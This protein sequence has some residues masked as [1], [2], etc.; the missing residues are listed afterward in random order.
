MD[1]FLTN[2]LSI[3]HFEPAVHIL[4]E[5]KRLNDM[6]ANSDIN[7]WIRFLKRKRFRRGIFLEDDIFIFIHINIYWRLNLLLAAKEA[8]PKIHSLWLLKFI[9]FVYTVS[10]NERFWKLRLENKYVIC[11]LSRKILIAWWNYSK[12]YKVFIL[13]IC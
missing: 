11:W 8:I 9:S 2:L 3:K 10:F 5:V 12:V 1:T 13:N 6:N 4:T 7:H